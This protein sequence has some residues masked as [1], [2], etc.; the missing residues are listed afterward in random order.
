[1]PVE[2]PPPVPPPPP[3]KLYS[4][5]LRV[6]SMIR[7]VSSIKTRERKKVI[8]TP[9]NIE[10][11]FDDFVS[12]I[13]SEIEL[14][15]RY[16]EELESLFLELVLKY[17]KE[18]ARKLN[19]ENFWISSKVDF[20]IEEKWEIERPEVLRRGVSEDEWELRVLIYEDKVWHKRG[21]YEHEIK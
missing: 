11:A 3:I 2:V 15:E 20:G 9:I 14:E 12:L 1:M 6:Y 19:W 18:I 7:E 17:R 16:R 8:E 4:Y 10:L 13:E 21:L 5:S